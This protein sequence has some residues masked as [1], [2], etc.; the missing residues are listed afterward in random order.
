M[1]GPRAGCAVRASFEILEILVLVRWVCHFTKIFA[2]VTQRRIRFVLMINSGRCCLLLSTL[3]NLPRNSGSMICSRERLSMRNLKMSSPPS[4]RR[5]QDF[6]CYGSS[7][8]EQHAWALILE[9]KPREGRWTLGCQYLLQKT[10]HYD[11][12]K[13]LSYSPMRTDAGLSKL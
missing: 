9:E 6:Q 12:I 4:E 8:K 10:A 2:L 3:S 13:H 5:F 11:G 1:N 7:R